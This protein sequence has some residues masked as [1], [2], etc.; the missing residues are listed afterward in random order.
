MNSAKNN[1]RNGGRSFQEASKEI[2]ENLKKHLEK[3]HE[4][5]PSD[6]EEESG[7]EEH[8]S[9]LITRLLSRYNGTDSEVVAGVVEN[10][11]N[12]LHS[13]VCLICISSINMWLN[14]DPMGR[15]ADIL[16]KL[17]RSPTFVF[18][19]A[20]SACKDKVSNLTEL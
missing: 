5:L 11:R 8:D 7:D 19:N 4:S 16:H 10:L 18:V 15:L 12:S 1:P 6:S 9:E 17:K 14:R 13:A 20:D 2:Q 3:Q